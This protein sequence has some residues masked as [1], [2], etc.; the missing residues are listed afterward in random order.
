MAMRPC[1]LANDNVLHYVVIRIASQSFSCCVKFI[2]VGS[3]IL[4]NIVRWSRV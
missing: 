3:Q 2:L 1:Q 4:L